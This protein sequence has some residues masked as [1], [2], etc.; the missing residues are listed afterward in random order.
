MDPDLEQISKKD[1]ILT[2]INPINEKKK[3]WLED[4]HDGTTKKKTTIANIF[5]TVRYRT[6]DP[7][8]HS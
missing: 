7:D 5:K 2:S 4:P 6:L 1:A 3:S 8:L